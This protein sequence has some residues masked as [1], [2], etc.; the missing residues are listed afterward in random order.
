VIAG[1]AA[2]VIGP[3]VFTVAP[4]PAAGQDVFGYR[5]A[6]ER[7]AKS[8]VRVSAGVLLAYSTN[9]QE[10]NIYSPYLLVRFDGTGTPERVVLTERARLNGQP[11]NTCRDTN[12]FGLCETLPLG[13][14]RPLPQRITLVRW[15]TR[16]GSEAVWATDTIRFEDAAGRP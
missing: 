3:A 7:T 13:A 16:V 11:L 2:A 10:G 6:A 14:G 4:I 1:A 12:P 15:R 9:L 5:P 8:R